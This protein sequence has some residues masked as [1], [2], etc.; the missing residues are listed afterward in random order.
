MKTSVQSVLFALGAAGLSAAMTLPAS[1]QQFK[2]RGCDNVSTSK[3]RLRSPTAAVCSRRMSGTYKNRTDCSHLF[4]RILRRKQQRAP[5]E[6][7]YTRA[8][9]ATVTPIELRQAMDRLSGLEARR[10]S[11]SV[12]TAVAEV[13]NPDNGPHHAGARERRVGNSGRCRRSTSPFVT[14]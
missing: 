8:A 1:A 7:W 9:T 10:N 13:R 14:S 6:Q 11:T 12:C 4:M 5:L 2:G 3:T